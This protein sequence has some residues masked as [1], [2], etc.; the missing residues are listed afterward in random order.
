MFVATAM[1]RSDADIVG[2]TLQPAA[3]AL[4]QR[5][6]QS[7]NSDLH[8]TQPKW[9]TSAMAAAAGSTPA[10]PSPASKAT[11]PSFIIDAFRHPLMVNAAEALVATEVDLASW[12][13]SDGSTALHFA[14][15][16]AVTL[17]GDTTP[18]QH[19]TTALDVL[20]RK[21]HIL[22]YAGVPLSATNNQGHTAT[23]EARLV[24][25]NQRAKGSAERGKTSARYIAT[26]ERVLEMLEK[27]QGA[28]NSLR[29]A[30]EGGRGTKFAVV[31]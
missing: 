11:P 19:P 23:H 9:L 13:S 3:T 24:I 12:R 30:T 20:A 22:L 6:W 29:M 8:T 26:V 4:L 15:S 31:R 28:G 14:L 18:M 17:G 2:L 10:S 27:L 25:Q 7:S 5:L 16:G 1:L 21:C